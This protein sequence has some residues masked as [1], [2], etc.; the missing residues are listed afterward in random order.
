MSQINHWLFKSD[1]SSYSYD[2]LLN[3]PDQT[4]EWDG[5]RNYQA[6]NMLRDQIKI[7]DQVL[8]YNSNSDP[9]AIVGT[10]VVVRSGY[11]DFTAWDPN[12]IHYDSTS[13]VENPRWYMVDIRAI[14][15][16]SIPLLLPILKV[17]PGLENMMLVQKRGSRLSIQPV[18]KAEWEI[19]TTISK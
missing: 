4:A 12:S 9:L 18:T 13:S 1:P 3:E 2:D 7:G 14:M 19:I 5:V 6:R 15:K 10:A 8:F 16:F 11:P 17:T